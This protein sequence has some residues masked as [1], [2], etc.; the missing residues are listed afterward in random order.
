MKQRSPHVCLFY[1]SFLPN[2]FKNYLTFYSFL[3][4][5][6]GTVQYWKVY[7]LLYLYSQ[8]SICILSCRVRIEDNV[9]KKKLTLCT[10]LFISLLLKLFGIKNAPLGRKFSLIQPKK[11]TIQHSEQAKQ[12]TKITSFEPHF[13]FREHIIHL[14]NH[15]PHKQTHT[16][17]METH[18]TDNNFSLN[19]AQ[20][21]PQNRIVLSHQKHRFTFMKQKPECGCITRG[22]THIRKIQ[23]KSPLI[24]H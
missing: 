6:N 3:F 13:I 8:L 14:H 23:T 24:I 17:L 15:T 1:L 19:W 18:S 5:P 2:N 9:I 22:Q 12:T 7:T 16:S 21:F 11:K 10:F 20:T 4:F